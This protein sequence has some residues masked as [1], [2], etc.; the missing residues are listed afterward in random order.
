MEALPPVNGI[1]RTGERTDFAAQHPDIV[2]ELKGL[3]A[4]WE[5]DVGPAR[6]R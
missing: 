6:N 5:T 4:R 1:S 2:V 3:L